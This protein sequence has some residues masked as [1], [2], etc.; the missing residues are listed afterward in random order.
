MSHSRN[1]FFSLITHSLLS[2]DKVHYHFNN[3]TEA[4]RFIRHLQTKFWSTRNFTHLK[5]IN[6][7]C[8]HGDPYQRCHVVSLSAKQFEEMNGE[9]SFSQFQEFKY[10]IENYQ[11][12]EDLI[13][14]DLH[15]SLM[16]EISLLIPTLSDH[17][18]NL[19]ALGKINDLNIM[20]SPLYVDKLLP[21]LTLGT[22]NTIIEINHSHDFIF[23]IFHH[24]RLSHD[25]LKIFTQKLGEDICK[26][27]I[28]Q[29]NQQIFSLNNEAQDILFSYLNDSELNQFILK[30]IH[31]N[32]LTEEII[33]SAIVL[34]NRLQPDT[35]AQFNYKRPQNFHL[36]DYHPEHRD[37]FCKNISKL[38]NSMFDYSHKIRPFTEQNSL[39]KIIGLESG[40]V[41]KD[42]WSMYA[43]EVAECFPP[44]SNEK[45]FFHLPQ[46]IEEE[47]TT[48]LPTKN[49]EDITKNWK[50]I[51]F[52]C[53]EGMPL[54]L[55]LQN[56]KKEHLLLRVQKKDEPMAMLAYDFKTTQYFQR[57][58]KTLNLKSY[59]PEPIGIMTVKGLIPW[60]KTE[61]LP[62]QFHEMMEFLIDKEK[63]GIY[64][65]KVSPVHANYFQFLHDK[66]LSHVEYQKANQIII[67][68]LLTMLKQ[69]IIFPAL[70]ILIHNSR[71][72]PEPRKDFGRF[73]VLANLLLDNNQGT[74][75]LER[76][77]YSILNNKTLLRASGI[78]H[79][80]LLMPIN[81]FIGNSKYT[82]RYF[83]GV[84]IAHR[85]RAVNYIIENFIAEYQYILF[86]LAGARGVSLEQ[87]SKHDPYLLWKNM[88]N[89]ILEN[90]AQSASFMTGQSQHV[91]KNIFSN[92]VNMNRVGRQMQYWMT[93]EYV[94]DFMENRIKENI[95][96]DDT[97]VVIDFES[98]PPGIFNSTHGF[99]FDLTYSDL[100]NLHGQEPIK[101]ANKLF[102]LM[103][104]YMMAFYL[105][106]K[107]TFEDLQKIIAIKD[108]V[109]SEN[110]R[111][112]S[113]KHLYGK[114]YH[115]IQQKLCEE[116]LY[117]N[118]KLPLGIQES[119][120][121]ELKQHTKEKAAFTIHYFW[122][123]YKKT[124]IL[125]N[126]IKKVNRLIL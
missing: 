2:S 54:L 94:F 4:S 83:K 93:K 78:V 10:S 84:A 113:F 29:Q 37:P 114:D 49:I 89:Q 71:S 125:E 107:L 123:H 60:L 79:W 118:Q 34:L 106:F 117:Q 33:L 57:E 87:M 61:L 13:I 48:L 70:A 90:C 65:A 44:V 64:L 1:E 56:D 25:E 75:R 35:I 76:W 16:E 43:K 110:L 63:H 18:C 41:S 6:Q 19:I 81:E 88:A 31:H 124:T 15:M 26:K 67:H 59:F 58:A 105:K 82:T 17:S 68:D 38:T 21:R 30:I 120:V 53:N 72:L 108:V 51:N 39:L 92:L 73:W 95:Y 36:T 100:G 103:T 7:R 40:G 112:T 86:L 12:G 32:D 91:L 85:N 97:H 99:S 28:Y 69:G 77:M 22:I 47:K 66:N 9:E 3:S 42:S 55:S 74:G 96:A 121:S 126:E 50:L 104:T 62:S 20:Q 11:T 111:K 98:L 45:Y 101:E 116:R 109:E 102:Y 115:A 119:I 80:H 5:R 52:E 46:R 23:H 27:F 122:R 8:Q 24:S 14:K